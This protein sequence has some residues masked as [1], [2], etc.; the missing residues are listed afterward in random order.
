MPAIILAI[1]VAVA[2]VVFYFTNLE[3]DEVVIDEPEVIIEESVPK[4]PMTFE[5]L[6]GEVEEKQEVL[7]PA[8]VEPEPVEEPEVEVEPTPVVEAVVEPEP[9]PVV[10][11]PEPEPQPVAQNITTTASYQVPSGATENIKV[12]FTIE[13]KI[14]TA[15]SAQYFDSVGPSK[16]YQ[17][18]FDSNFKGEV[19][20]KDIDSVALFRVGGA[21][22]T[23][24]AFNQA[25]AA[26]KAQMSQG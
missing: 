20:G 15:V 16:G 17:A 13:D 5:E 26:A 22:L 11:E 18:G 14:V 10:E 25:V 4:E 19:L 12:S 7:E 2:T 24:K 6:N 21:S 3:Q 23:S 1:I 9:E 8:V